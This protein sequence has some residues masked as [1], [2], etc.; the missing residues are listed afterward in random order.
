MRRSL[1]SIIAFCVLVTMALAPAD[2][3]AKALANKWPG[4]EEWNKPPKQLT[5]PERAKLTRR[6]WAWN[7]GQC[8]QFQLDVTADVFPYLEAW[9]FGQDLYWEVIQPNWINPCVHPASWIIVKANSPYRIMISNVNPLVHHKTGDVIPTYYWLR[10][11]W[12]KGT[13]KAGGA[14]IL[15]PSNMT[16]ESLDAR[17]GG[18][19]A[20][21]KAGG[22][23]KGDELPAGDFVL[24]EKFENIDAQCDKWPFKMDGV[25]KKV[26]EGVLY[27]SKEETPVV[28][29]GGAP[30][31]C[32][33]FALYM[34]GA[35]LAVGLEDDA[36]EACDSYCDGKNTEDCVYEAKGGG[37]IITI[38]AYLPRK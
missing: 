26:G 23:A 15:D 30:G 25:T 5:Y 4:D 10:K 19:G 9:L 36:T 8:V 37:P 33:R 24:S 28:K 6:G 1:L 3:S 32:Y 22:A 20:A 17:F 12:S 27:A 14:A 2:V 29:A 16:L 34:L 13:V 31:W 11:I 35:G 7:H 38:C 18:P 21:V